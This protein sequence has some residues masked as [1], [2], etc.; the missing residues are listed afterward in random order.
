MRISTDKAIELILY[1]LAE[2]IKIGLDMEACVDAARN[3]LL[4]FWDKDIKEVERDANTVY[5]KVNL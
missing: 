1:A 3:D 4:D 2:K 5:N